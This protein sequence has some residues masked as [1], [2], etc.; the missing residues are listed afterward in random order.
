MNMTQQTTEAVRPHDW[1]GLANP[2]HDSQRL[3]RQL[4]GAMSEPGTLTELVLPALPAGAAISPAAWGALLALCDLDTRVWVD[5]GLARANLAAALAF[6]TGARLTDDPAQADLALVTPDTLSRE[7]G[8]AL[9]SDAWPDRS[10]TLIVMVEALA[11]G[12][13]WWLSGPGVPG[14]RGLALG[15]AERALPLMRVLAANRARFPRGLDA[16]ISSGMRLTAIARSTRLAGP[17]LSGAGLAETDDA[18]HQ[19]ETA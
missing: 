10:T 12:E 7:D 1:P 15:N 19:E 6:H 17:G 9:G 13:D 11:Q 5:E 16:F 3:F 2:V 4:L 14:Q 8:F 18:E